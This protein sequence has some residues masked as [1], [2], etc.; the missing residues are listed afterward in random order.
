MIDEKFFRLYAESVQLKDWG[1]LKSSLQ[2]RIEATQLMKNDDAYY[3]LGKANEMI[4][5][6]FH[7]GDGFQARAACLEALKDLDKNGLDSFVKL[8]KEWEKQTGFSIMRDCLDYAILWSESF[9]E[10][11]NYCQIL[12]KYYS[13]GSNKKHQ[14]RF[15]RQ[16]CVFQSG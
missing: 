15:S 8:D 7:I 3:R 6:G 14:R 2:K 13:S 12:I 5:L 11:I 4:L 16:W 9:D 1:L 10:A